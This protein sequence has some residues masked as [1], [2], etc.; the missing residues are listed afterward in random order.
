MCGLCG[1]FRWDG[2][3]ADIAAVSRM[4]EPLA[5]RGPNGSGLWAQRS[6]SRSA[7]A[8]CRSS[9]FR[10]R[11]AQPM[12]DSDLGLTVAFNG[13]IYNYPAA[14]RGTERRR[15]PLL[16]HVRHR[17]RAQGLP[18][19]G[20][21]VRRALRGHVRLR[22]LRAEH[23]AADARPRPARHQA[24]LP[25]RVTRS[26][27]VRLDASRA[28]RRRRDRHFARSGRAAPLHEL[29]FGRAGAAHDPDGRAQAAAG[30]GPHRQRRRSHDR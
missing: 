11:A 21:G 20:N 1:E 12:V 19:L 2:K 14:A 15:L 23:R 6:G 9:I 13:C 18:P 10:R 7:T 8:G 5:P 4:R 25:G 26:A 30:D 16:L 22:H 24:A 27:A 28:R 3:A 17:S 29:P